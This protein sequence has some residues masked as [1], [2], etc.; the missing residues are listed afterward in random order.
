MELFLQD[1]RYAVRSLSRSRGFTAVA[2]LVLGLGIAVNTAIFS[3]VNGVLLKPLPYANPER[4][5]MLWSHWEN[6]PQ[7]WVSP[8]EFADYA[9]EL[10]STERVAA[11]DYGS[12]NLT[13]GDRPER[14]RAGFGS[15]ELFPTLG[16]HAKRGRVFTVRDDVPG[17]PRVAV[18][19]DGLW[20]RRFGGDPGVLGQTIRLSDSLVTVIGIMTAGFELPLDFGQP[21]DL[22][23]PLALGIPDPNDRGSHGLNVVARL[24]AGTSIEAAQKDVDALTMRLRATYPRDYDAQFGAS[25]VPVKMQVAG[26]IGPAL[27]VLLGA[28]GFVLLI[29]C[30]NVANLLLARAES[31]EREIAVR[32][33]LGAGRGRIVRQLLTESAVL[34]V[35]GG[36]LGLLLAVAGLRA[37]VAMAPASVPRIAEVG[38][39]ARVLAFTAAVA[40][41]TAILF[42]LAPALHATRGELH[43]SLKSGARGGSAGA[44]RLRLRR[45]LAIGEIAVS[46]VLVIGACLLVQSFA[47]LRNVNPGFDPERVLTMRVS[48]APARYPGG[49]EVRAF[50]GELIARARVLPGVL[51]VGAVRVLPMTSVI[52]DWGFAIEG[53]QQGAGAPN[54]SQGDWQVVTPDYFR[55]M[56]IPLKRGRSLSDADD[57]RAPGAIMFNEAL[58]ARVFPGQDAVGHRVRMGGDTVWRTI[59][60]VVGNVRHRG[61]DEEARP[62]L[63]LPHA[64]WPTANG[65]TQRAMVLTLRT[66]GEPTMAAAALLREVRALDPD[67]P[68]SEVQPMVDVLGS[69]IGER[70]LTMLVLGL[71]AGTALVLA[72]V[73]TYGVLAYTVAQRTR[74]IGIRI[75]L[76]ARAHD[77]VS[78]IVRQ[79]TTLAVT[80]VLVG[81]VAALL[82]TRLLAGLLYG[83]PPRDPLTFAG[84]ATLLFVMAVGAA[85]VPARRA[86]R[87]EPTEALR[88]E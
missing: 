70:R 9:R 21:V 55:A 61:L 24:R 34:A 23:M 13:G 60:G 77:V 2:V 37:L 19:S 33:A 76:G 10:R 57:D 86:T 38:I 16:A 71:L 42:G 66:P 28:V 46:L 32:T 14:I 79:G 36:T 54:H 22:W 3:V 8:P 75:A 40:V 27:L 68:V 69:W 62:E 64:Q 82:L 49:R 50:Y 30:A 35:A 78:M 52:G 80:G 7:T 4:V 53:R 47:R 29:A 15:G 85:Y 17:A 74:E 1:L 48:L 81:T 72:A 5:V 12:R 26:K 73:G 63:Y 83:V 45:M 6:W 43:D 59:V 65:P 18:I 87:V 58:A 41:A 44:P 88:A 20:R 67:V 84:V 31:R 25:L 11:F 51:S 39:D 56:H